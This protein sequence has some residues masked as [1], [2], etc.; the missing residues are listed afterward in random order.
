MMSKIVIIILIYHC[1]KPIDLI[2]FNTL[3]LC[4]L[5]HISVILNFKVVSSLGIYI[6]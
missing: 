4:I 3:I 1:H 2:I 5:L 6:G